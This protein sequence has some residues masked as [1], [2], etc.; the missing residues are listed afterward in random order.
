M[1]EI[2]LF[3]LSVINAMILLALILLIFYLALLAT[4]NEGKIILSQI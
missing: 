1:P 3:P 4:I 2:L